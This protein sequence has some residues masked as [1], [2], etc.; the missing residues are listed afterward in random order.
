MASIK[1]DLQPHWNKTFRPLTCRSASDSVTYVNPESHCLI[2]SYLTGRPEFTLWFCISQT[3]WKYKPILP[4]EIVFLR[5]LT[6]E[7]PIPI[8]GAMDVFF[9]IVSGNEH[10]SFDVQKRSHQGMIMGKK[11]EAG[12]CRCVI[13]EFHSL[14]PRPCPP[15]G[16]VRQL[17]PVPGPVNISL[18]VAMNYIKSGVISHCNIVFI[19]I[20]ISELWFW[21]QHATGSIASVQWQKQLPTRPGYVCVVLTCY[22]H[23]HDETKTFSEDTGV[24]ALWHC[25]ATAEL[26][27]LQGEC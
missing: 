17:K 10:F 5:T 16:V 1:N 12:T 3:N 26:K 6:A 2:F 27:D 19:H 18:E 20:F 14:I 11:E 4:S 21:D 8:L 13:C 25:E 24:R 22:K 23:T 9:D 7:N 15:A